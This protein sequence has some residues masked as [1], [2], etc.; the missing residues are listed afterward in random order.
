MAG[1]KVV[2]GLGV[3]DF[4]IAPRITAP[5]TP[6]WRDVPGV[7]EA[8]FTMGV[9]EV[10]QWGDDVLYNT[11]YHSQKGTLA[12]RAS[13][14]ALAVLE[15]LSGSPV[16][17]SGAVEKIDIGRASELTPTRLSLRVTVENL[18][19][20][21][22]NTAVMTTYF[23]NASV[24]SVWESIPRAT[25][26][27]LQEVTLNFNVYASDTDETGATIGQATFGRMEI[28]S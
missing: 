11:F 24:R 20:K 25:L 3:R 12:V 6:V 22:G 27:A 1:T 16:T 28:N 26:G 21:D 9:S 15:A 5:G 14:L 7:T 13:F 8:S 23:Y 10:D 4:Q 2:A 18:K 17:S 19:T